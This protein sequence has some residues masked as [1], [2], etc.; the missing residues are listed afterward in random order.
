MDSTERLVS[1]CMLIVGVALLL[2]GVVSGTPVRHLIQVI[3][4]SIA[5]ALAA[6]RSP[7]APSAALAIFAFWLS[8]MT[9]IWLWLLGLASVVTGQFSPTEIGLTIA[10]GLGCGLGGIAALRWRAN[11]RWAARIAVFLSF[12]VLQIGAL[13]ASLQP[14]VA[15]R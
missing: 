12:A 5:F 11:G 13:W 9:L 6:R 7:W 1:L 15:G 8:I 14:L 2:V 4:V 3:P 10:I